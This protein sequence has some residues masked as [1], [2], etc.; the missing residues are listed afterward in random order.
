MLPLTD[1][2]IICEKY[3]NIIYRD[4]IPDKEEQHSRANSIPHTYGEIL[5][6]A[7]TKLIGTLQLNPDD[8]F[9][10][11]GSGKGKVVLQ[12]FLQTCVQAA[13]GIELSPALHHAALQAA[14][15]IQLDAPQCYDHGRQLTFACGSFF[16]LPFDTATIVLIG[17]PCF[18]PAMLSTLGMLINQISSIH[19]VISL[20]P[21]TTLQRLTFKN[22]MRVE[23]SWDSALCYIYSVNTT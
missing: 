10:D 3:L 1:P 17:S 15:R 22:M 6:P 21:I 2:N 5:Y 14:K 7:V 23:C 12:F 16:D 20:R 4:M 9:F 8:I 18:S 13:H 11:L 19:T